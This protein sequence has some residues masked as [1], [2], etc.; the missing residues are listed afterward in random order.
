MIKF[1]SLSQETLI[2]G[3]AIGSLLLFL[4]GAGVAALF[5][6]YA[7]SRLARGIDVDRRRPPTPRRRR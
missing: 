1:G 3:V 4:I 6:F 7:K 2:A 5:H